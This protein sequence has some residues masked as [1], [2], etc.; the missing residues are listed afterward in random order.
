[1]GVIDNCAKS[2]L[3][4]SRVC[5]NLT[6]HS[7]IVMWH[8]LATACPRSRNISL[9]SRAWLQKFLVQPPLLAFAFDEYRL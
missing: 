8:K 7:P 5:I 4:F 3:V 1:M 6:S 2:Q 9:E